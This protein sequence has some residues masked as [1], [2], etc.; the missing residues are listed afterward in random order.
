MKMA[1]FKDIWLHARNLPGSHTILV[2]EG[3][4]PTD[5]AIE[6]AAS[7]AAFYSK[8]KN[9]PLAAIDYTMVKY[10]KK[11]PKAKPGMVTYSN[12][13]TAF[14]KPCTLEETI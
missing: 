5:K 14:V 9:Q 10:G 1:D 8:M 12:F 3:R 13:K 4:E 7:V 11:I 6:E 2:L